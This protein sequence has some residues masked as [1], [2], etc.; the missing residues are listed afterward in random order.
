M[1][2]IPGWLIS[3]VTFP[4]IIV[5]EAAHMLFCRLRRVPVLEVCFLRFAN[6]PGYVIHEAPKDFTSNFLIAVGPFI[7]NTLLCLLLCFPSFLRVRVFDLPDPL[8][9]LMLWLGV[10][11]GMHAFPSNQDASCLLEGAKAA[12]RRL[13]P[14]ALLSFPLVV[15]IY[16]ANFLRFF[17]FDYLY[18][19]A[20][21]LLLPE[22][23][24]K[25]LA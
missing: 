15:L 21:G 9:Y 16:I 23:L 3:I 24:L 2:F 6:P 25:R 20:V 17:W 12:A 10:S 7:V 1:F 4:G 22:L 8:S 18:G 13:N 5:H 14:L 19:F 11:I